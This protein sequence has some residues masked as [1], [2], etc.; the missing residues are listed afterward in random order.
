MI[1][2]KTMAAVLGTAL[3]VASGCAMIRLH[4]D[5][6]RLSGYAL[7]GGHVS[8][9]PAD[10]PVIVVLTS[11]SPPTIVDSYYLP[12]PGPYFFQ[13]P[14][15][16]YRIAAF[17][18]A[19]GDATYEPA[20]EAA[21]W[22]G[23]PTDVVAAPGQRLSD[24]DVRFGGPG[25]RLDFPITAVQ[26]GT[27]SSKDLPAIALGDLIKL[28]DPRFS[29]ENGKLG[30]WQ[31]VEFLFKVGGGYF[32]LQPFDEKKIPVLFVHGA[33]GEPGYFRDLITHLDQ[34]RFQPWLLY[35]PSGLGL[36]AT[37]RG[38]ARWMSVLASRYHFKR[39]VIVA[40]S[41][42]GVVAR[43]TIN[44]MVANGDGGMV[45]LFVSM[46]TPWNGH[47][48]AAYGADAPVV[49]PMWTDM[50]PDSPFL[51]NLFATPLPAGCPFHLMFSY[52]GRSLREGQAN[53]GV[54]ELVS[55]LAPAAQHAAAR[56]YGFNE[57][58]M[59]ILASRE[60]SDTLNG[61]LAGVSR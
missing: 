32:F 60:A 53:D 6:T 51:K 41:M 12:R 44:N 17:V 27:R 40:H 39:I 19:N 56:I 22:Y 13:V 20:T 28:D 48:G 18:D 2:R 54:V 11:G 4:K 42:G 5:V 43:A 52:R 47:S 36:D 58:H 26:A 25:V 35:Y 10:A 9:Q 37:A 21:A 15:G 29:E 57:S 8:G 3:V 38:A 16:Q 55:E 7:L 1:R 14:A 45:A 46:S 50:V 34:T 33:G 23:A 61:I 59:S 31:P 49:M 24:L 30:L